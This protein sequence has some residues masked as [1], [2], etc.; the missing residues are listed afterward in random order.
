MTVKTI[1]IAD[2]EPHVIRVMQLALERAGYEVF[3]VPNGEA[4]YE[5]LSERQPDVLITDIQMPRMTG[6]QLCK[7]IS[8]HYPQRKFLIFVLTSR[9]EVEHR[10]W[11]HKLDNVMFL[12][13]PVSTRK[14]IKALDEYFMRPVL[15]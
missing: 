5:W 2:D 7:K 8:E 14:L 4:A 10:D 6:E 11:S 1:L 9:T 15:D 12:E 3:S 13:K